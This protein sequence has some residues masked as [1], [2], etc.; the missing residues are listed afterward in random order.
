VNGIDQSDIQ[1]RLERGME[2]SG[3]IAFEGTS[4]EPP[5]DLSRVSIRLST[6]PSPGGVTVSVNA[7][8]AQV[9]PDGTFMLEGVTPGRY[10][11][12]ASTP[13]IAPAPG[14]GW[15]V[16]SIRV[17]DADAVDVPF[18]VRPAQNISDVVVTFTDRMAELSG[19]LFDA[20]GH[21]TSELSIV[22]FSTDRTMWSQRSRRVRSPV[23]ASTDGKFKFTSLPAGEYYVAA[24]ADFEPAEYYKPEFLEQVAAVA[25]K[26]TLADG[27]K[28]VQ[29]LKIA[30]QPPV[31]GHVLRR[32]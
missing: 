16:K 31:T 12:S 28:K 14:G 22:L 1:L 27:E 21:P 17:G 29:D 20:A 2:L 15:T 6:A 8:S 9:A 30:G 19:T 11:L 5:A 13:A 10:F 7:P 32:F 25:M 3:R 23:R 4:L 26:V 18:E 24:L